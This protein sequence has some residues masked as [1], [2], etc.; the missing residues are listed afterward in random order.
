MMQVFDKNDFSAEYVNTYNDTRVG[1]SLEL[2]QAV[3]SRVGLQQDQ[4]IV[5]VGSGTGLLAKPFLDLGYTVIGVEPSRRMREMAQFAL[6]RYPNF[7]SIDASAEKSTLNQNS[8]DLVLVG[9]AA[10]Q[11]MNEEAKREIQTILK[12][13]GSLVLVWS[14]LA[15]E[16]CPTAEDMHRLILRHRKEENEFIFSE[17]TRSMAEGF[18]GKSNEVMKLANQKDMDL[19]ALLRYFSIYP[20]SPKPMD[21]WYAEAISQL[22]DIFEDHQI[23]GVVTLKYDVFVYIFSAE[24]IR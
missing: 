1:Y 18:A 20:L 12:P 2:A 6:S 14:Y 19:N 3:A 9:Q 17:T 13:Q 11:F 8:A 22:K 5:D 21:G 4:T 7:Q 10:H 15:E 23:G 16:K 24:N